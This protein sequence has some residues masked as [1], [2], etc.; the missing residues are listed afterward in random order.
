VHVEL[1]FHSRDK[2][3]TRFKKNLRLG[4]KGIYLN[5]IR[6]CIKKPTANIFSDRKLKA[7][8][9]NIKIKANISNI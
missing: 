6:Q 8:S 2:S 5:I 7:L 9:S 3:H 4:L 1:F